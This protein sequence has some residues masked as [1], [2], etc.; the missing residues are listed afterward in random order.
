MDIFYIYIMMAPTVIFLTKKFHNL[1]FLSSYQNK[2]LDD[3]NLLICHSPF[4]FQL[5][6]KI[7]Q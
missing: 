4:L 6:G 1:K 5:G 2:M 3:E 7:K